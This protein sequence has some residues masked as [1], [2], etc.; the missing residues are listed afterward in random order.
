MNGEECRKKQEISYLKWW[1]I[2]PLVIVILYLVFSSM[3]TPRQEPYGTDAE[4]DAYTKVM[5]SR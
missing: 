1:V 5:N 3:N 2:L 4:W